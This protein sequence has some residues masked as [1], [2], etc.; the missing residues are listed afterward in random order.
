MCISA[1]LHIRHTEKRWEDVA[2]QLAKVLMDIH[3][4]VK[5]IV[6]KKHWSCPYIVQYVN[7]VIIVAFVELNFDVQICV[8]DP[9]VSC[10]DSIE[11]T[12]DKMI[13]VY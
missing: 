10:V 1:H 5:T 7:H 12:I 4:Y 13:V 6:S 2:A 8:T 3:S 9:I 11:G